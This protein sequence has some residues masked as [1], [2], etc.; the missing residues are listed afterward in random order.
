[1]ANIGKHKERE[2]KMSEYEHGSMDI[3]DQEKTYHSFLMLGKWTAYICIGILVFLAI[4][5]T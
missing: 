3:Y 4:V 1:M 2:N 5:G